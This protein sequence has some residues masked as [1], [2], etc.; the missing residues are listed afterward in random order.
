MDIAFLVLKMALQTI[1]QILESRYK[2]PSILHRVDEQ[3]EKGIGVNWV[4][5]PALTRLVES[6]RKD[7]PIKILT[8]GLEYVVDIED[9][10]K[11]AA[12]A[13]IEILGLGET[14]ALFSYKVPVVNPDYMDPLEPFSAAETH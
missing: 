14:K 4:D 11:F 9:S 13:T 10:G 6:I 7:H 2:N 12:D 5:S 1:N 3:R 8:D